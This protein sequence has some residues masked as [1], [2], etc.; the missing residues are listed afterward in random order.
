MSAIQPQLVRA[1]A[2]AGLALT[3]A[4]LTQLDD[5]G[6]LI[7]KWNR[8]VN[9]VGSGSIEAIVRAHIGDCLA[10]VPFIEG[11]RLA[12]IGSGAGLPG[13]V[14]AIARP[15]FSVALVESR[16][17]KCRFLRQAVIEL[18]L[19]NV[20]VIASRIEHWQAPHAMDALTCRGY[21]SLAKFF[22]DTRALHHPGLRLYAMKGA[23]GDDEID[24]VASARAAVDVRRLQVPGWDHRH[25]VTIS[26]GA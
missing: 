26:L 23:I 25:L 7:E 8:V 22:S 3:P 13:L 6:R 20:T 16:Q 12:D 19:H 1:A 15:Q 2:A 9:L 17:R 14:I 21:S 4:Q 10:A 11:A 5:Y 24:A 18:G